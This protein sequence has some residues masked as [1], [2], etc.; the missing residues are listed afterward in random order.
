MTEN[1]GRS[2]SFSKIVSEND[3]PDINPQQISK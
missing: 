2:S 1:R 3:R